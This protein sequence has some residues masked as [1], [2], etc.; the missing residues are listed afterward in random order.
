M[1]STVIT[2]VKNKIALTFIHEVTFIK[3]STIGLFQNQ[4]HVPSPYQFVMGLIVTWCDTS[5]IILNYFP[6]V[7][8]LKR[9]SVYLFFVNNVYFFRYIS[10]FVRTCRWL[11]LSSHVGVK[12]TEL[13]LHVLHHGGRALAS[14][15]WTLLRMKCSG[16]ASAKFQTH[17]HELCG[18]YPSMYVRQKVLFRNRSVTIILTDS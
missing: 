3:V 9:V 10:C 13:G 14:V 4:Q 12:E 8:L 17:E 1:D 15:S 16:S 7:R 6:Q 5:I 2:D 11:L 18:D